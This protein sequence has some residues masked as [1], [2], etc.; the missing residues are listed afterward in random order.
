MVENDLNGINGRN[1]LKEIIHLMKSKLN[2]KQRTIHLGID[3]VNNGKPVGV[4]SKRPKKLVKFRAGSLRR[5][6]TVGTTP[7]INTTVGTLGTRE[8]SQ[9][10][11]PATS[12]DTAYSKGSHGTK[13]SLQTSLHCHFQFHLHSRA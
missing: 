6:V 11:Q 2:K 10:E 3:F 4:T 1:D 5:T 13:T 12:G 7:R 8:T 9:E